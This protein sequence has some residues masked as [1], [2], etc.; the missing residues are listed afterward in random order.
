MVRGKNDLAQS[1]KG[2]KE[3]LFV[4]ILI[5]EIKDWPFLANFAP[6]HEN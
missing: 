4:L 3:N 5:S 1:R 2:R 6:L